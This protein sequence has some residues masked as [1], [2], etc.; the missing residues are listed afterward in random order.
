MG[1]IEK[2]RM[3]SCWQVTRL[4][5][6]CV[7]AGVFLGLAAQPKT[8]TTLPLLA[9]AQ[10]TGGDNQ[11]QVAG[12][13]VSVEVPAINY[14]ARGGESKIEFSPT[15]LMPSARGQGRVKVLK[16]GDA[17]VE[18]QFTGLTGTTKFGNEFLTYMLW[19]SVPQGRTLKIGELAV[20]GD[21]GQVVA[22]TALHTFAMMVTA[23]P[24][25]AV[26]QPSRLVILNGASPAADTTQTAPAHIELL[27]DAYAPPG[28]NYEPLDTS[29]GYAPEIIQAMNARRIAKVL[30]TEKY[31]AQKFQA[32]EDLYQYMIGSAIQGKKESKQLL[33][34]AKAVAESYEEARAISI[35][36]QQNSK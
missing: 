18:V 1:L 11:K 14:Y 30:Q 12:N 33:G 35:R 5:G 17:S 8:H 34:A 19:G 36:Q 7:V 10:N 9:G 24:Y 13:P 23:E 6:F 4:I 32:A 26:T 22:T 16:E 20:K 27:G 25:A 21:R 31:A 2:D 3:S 15:P 29:S 28:Y